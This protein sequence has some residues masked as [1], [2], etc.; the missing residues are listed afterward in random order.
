M[1]RRRRPSSRALALP[2]ALAVVGLAGTL[3]LAAPTNWLAVDGG[4]RFNSVTGATYDWANSG[5]GAAHLCPAGAV[6]LNGAGGLFNCGRPGAGFNPPIAPTLTP[7]AAADKSIISAIFIADGISSD[8]T[9]CGKGDP[10]TI[11]GSVKNGDAIS[12]IGA[13]SGSVPDKDDLV[14]VYAVSHTRSDTGHPEVFFAAERL[15]NNGES[16]IDFEFLQSHLGLATVACSGKFTG[17]R[18]EGDLLVAVDFTNGG[19]TAG[20]TVY[21]WHCAADP[22]PQPADGTVCDPATVEHYEP[23]AVPSFLTFVVNTSVTPI[24]CGGWVCRDKVTGITTKVAPEDFLEGGID[25]AGIPFTGCFNSFLPHTRTAQSFTSGLMDFAG[26][27]AFHSCRNPAISSTS[28]P[29]NNLNV[30][31]GT[32]VTDSVNVASGGAGFTP[33]GTVTF[34]LCGPGQTS[35]GGC[36]GGGTQIGS[37]KTLVSGAATSDPTSSSSTVGAYCWRTVFAPDVT[38][39]GVFQGATHTNATTECFG[40]GGVGLPNTAGPP[41]GT[42]DPVPPLPSPALALLVIIPI[43][44]VV[45]GWRRERALGLVMLASLSVGLLPDALEPASASAPAGISPIARATQPA[46]AT[47]LATSVG[48]SIAGVAQVRTGWRLVIPRLGVDASIQ[49]VGLDAQHAMAVP[50]TLDSVGWFNQGPQPGESG[51]AVIAGHYGL[52]GNPAVFRDLGR[53]RPGD[54]FEVI[55]PDGHSVHFRVTSSALVAANGPPPAGVFSRA[56][57]ARLSLITCGGDWLQAKATYSER[58]IVNAVPV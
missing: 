41:A 43:V 38:S 44:L 52:P 4:I 21:Q 12:T 7:V 57:P 51:D 18:T 11:A 14:N 35:P 13:A 20:A 5:A 1:L 39:T 23:I 50:P 22:G 15:T 32:P 17:H 53:L 48:R 27:V 54:T 46:V 49:P 10:T 25:L 16:H 40:V 56:G 6:N 47:H 29:N 19:N 55:W 26:P 9:S 8:T 36:P 31:P 2:L 28:A 3:A 58:L 42:A 45:A 24:D 37:P 30:A 33:T 34:F